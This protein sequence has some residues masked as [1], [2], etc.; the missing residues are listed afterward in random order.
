MGIPLLKSTI[1]LPTGTACESSA[2]RVTVGSHEPES[3]TPTSV[4]VG[5]VLTGVG[6]ETVVGG[7]GVVTGGGEVATGGGVVVG[8]GEV[9]VG[10]GEVVVGGEVVGGETAV[11]PYVTVKP[12]PALLRA[13]VLAWVSPNWESMLIA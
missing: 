6:G 9:V 8:G 10:G 11:S 1:P 2:V 5:A 7:E 13:D 4:T 12:V 3:A